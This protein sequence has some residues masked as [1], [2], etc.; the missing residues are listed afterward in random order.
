MKEK[1]IKSNGEI[2]GFEN[3]YGDFV[4]VYI[5]SHN[6]I[7]ITKELGGEIFITTEAGNGYSYQITQETFAKIQTK[8]KFN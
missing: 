2:M 7:V 6:P 4:L 3:T 8:F 5:D 1:K